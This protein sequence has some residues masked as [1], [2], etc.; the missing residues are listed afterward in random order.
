ML[1][2]EFLLN[3]TNVYNT[4]KSQLTAFNNC[5]QILSSCLKTVNGGEVWTQPISNFFLLEESEFEPSYF[6]KAL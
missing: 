4:A 2:E 1:L 6:K 5:I 3:M